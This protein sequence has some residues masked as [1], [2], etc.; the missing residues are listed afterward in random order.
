MRSK[1][2]CCIQHV[3]KVLLRPHVAGIQDHGL[4]FVDVMCFSEGT[5]PISGRNQLRISP[6]SK[7]RTFRSRYALA[8]KIGD[9]LFGNDEYLARAA[10]NE[11]LKEPS[12]FD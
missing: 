4:R 12:H 2:A 8:S 1:S 5:V 6:K 3:L 10:V 9:E 11:F 7:E